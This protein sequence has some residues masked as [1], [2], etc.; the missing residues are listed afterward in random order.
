ML[1]N[2]TNYGWTEVGRNSS[3]YVSRRSIFRTHSLKEQPRSAG[4]PP[5]PAP[6]LLSNLMT[7]RTR[8][9]N[10]SAAGS[11][12]T[13]NNTSLRRTGVLAV[14]PE[15]QKREILSS[16]ATSADG[17][18]LRIISSAGKSPGKRNWERSRPNKSI[19]RTERAPEWWTRTSPAKGGEERT[20]TGRG[21]LLRGAFLHGA[22]GKPDMVSWFDRQLPE[23]RKPREEV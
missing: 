15:P 6:R 1:P 14:G 16:L 9:E 5:P 21:H 18:D 3:S 19:N 4:G 11:D 2:R 10:V 13:Q 7:S 22:P 20:L 8:I 17:W 12:T 23:G